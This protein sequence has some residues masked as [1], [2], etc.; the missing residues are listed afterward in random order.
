MATVRLQGGPFDGTQV[1]AT[2][3]IIPMGR[4]EGGKVTR[5]LYVGRGPWAS[6]PAGHRG[7]HAHPRRGL[8][9]LLADVV[10]W[11]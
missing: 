10:N 3:T 9:G 8:G 11:E 2:D 5:Y 4:I 6:G 1:K 7:S